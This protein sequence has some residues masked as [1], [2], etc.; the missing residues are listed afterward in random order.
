MAAGTAVMK[1]NHPS[2]QR[3][4]LHV[5]ETG[6]EHHFEN[7]PEGVLT[8]RVT[9]EDG[10]EITSTRPGQSA[11]YSQLVWPPGYGWQPIGQDEEFTY[12]M[13]GLVGP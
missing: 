6:V 13:R 7:E 11:A 10:L 8:V 5:D 3:Y 9:N 4:W 12:W 1:S 2:P